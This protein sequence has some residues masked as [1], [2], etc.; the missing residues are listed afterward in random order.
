MYLSITPYKCMHVAILKTLSQ[1]IW[2]T[3]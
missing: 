1:Q 3:S 2:Q